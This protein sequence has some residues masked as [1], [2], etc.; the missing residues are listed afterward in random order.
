MNADRTVEALKTILDGK[1]PEEIDAVVRDLKQTLD[2]AAADI[3]GEMDIDS[4]AVVSDLKDEI[5]Q[6]ST[7]ESAKNFSV[8]DCVIPSESDVKIK[9][10]NRETD[11]TFVEKLFKPVV[12]LDSSFVCAPEGLFGDKLEFVCSPVTVTSCNKGGDDCDNDVF[13][14]LE[15]TELNEELLNKIEKEK[16]CDEI[17]LLNEPI[18]PF[19]TR[20]FNKKLSKV[21]AEI[22]SKYNVKNNLKK[23]KTKEKINDI[24]RKVHLSRFF[25][26]SM[27]SID[28]HEKPIYDAIREVMLKVNHLDDDSINQRYELVAS[29]ID[30]CRQAAISNKNEPILYSHPL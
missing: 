9:S 4:T 16:T 15:V 26:F 8:P 14:N 30:S 2:Q 17:T 18:Q 22:Y 13:N 6:L 21:E 7:I 3:K 25:S 5:N 1:T 29:K 19:A 27:A 12:T 23:I 20:L 28:K 10:C 24:L 11:M